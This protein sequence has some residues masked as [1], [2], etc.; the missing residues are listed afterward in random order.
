MNKSAGP[1]PNSSVAHGLPPSSI[2]SALI[3]T[4]CSISSVSRP[5][6]TKAGSVVVKFLAVFG[7]PRRTAPRSAAVRDS[8][9]GVFASEA[10]G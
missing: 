9:S 5:G 3:S 7:G 6:S 4:P 2:G 10:G 8:A 1:N